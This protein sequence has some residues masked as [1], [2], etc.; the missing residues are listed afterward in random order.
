VRDADVDARIA[1]IES[2]EQ[3]RRTTGQWVTE[4]RLNGDQTNQ[5]RQLML[6]PHRVQIYRVRLYS[7]PREEKQ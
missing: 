4:K 3:V 2:G 6:D 1:G 5:G 7:I